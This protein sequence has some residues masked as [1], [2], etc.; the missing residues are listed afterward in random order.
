MLIILNIFIFVNILFIISILLKRNNIIDV[1]WGPGIFLATLSS[2]IIYLQNNKFVSYFPIILTF[3]IFLWAIR[4]FLHI[5]SRFIKEKEED[6]RYKNWREKWKYFYLRSY[7]Q[8][9]ILQGLL[10]ILVSS[11]LIYFNFNF[12]HF[13]NIYFQIIFFTGIVLALSALLFETIADL[14]LKKFIQ[15]KKENK[16]KDNI[17][18]TGLWRHTRHPNYFG[19]I[20]FWWSTF[21]STSSL[22]FQNV[23]SQN[24]SN[25]LLDF[26]YIILGPSIITFLILK[27]SGIPK[28]EKKYEESEDGNTKKEWQE[29][30]SKTP[31]FFPKLF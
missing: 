28:L 20:M 15:L 29:Y 24:I 8:I 10:M 19:E 25:N 5:G 12:T 14:Q 13:E 1:F 31:A 2:F 22:F 18:K 16:I 6:F 7:F 21:L 17:L 26:F 9:Y 3:V 11:S 23:F 4:I 30:K 27:V